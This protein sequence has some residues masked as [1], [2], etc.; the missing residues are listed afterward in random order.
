MLAHN[1][2]HESTIAGRRRRRTTPFDSS[3]SSDVFLCANGVGYRHHL[4]NNIARYDVI[5]LYMYS[6]THMY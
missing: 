5:A 6:D 4:I 3:S 1:D 2:L